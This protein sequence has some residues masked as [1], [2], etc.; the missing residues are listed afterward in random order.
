ME[1]FVIEFHLNFRFVADHVSQRFNR[2]Q[3]TTII[4]KSRAKV[5]EKLKR[6]EK[7]YIN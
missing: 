3:S 5:L 2:F 6:T 4:I 1:Q 7:V